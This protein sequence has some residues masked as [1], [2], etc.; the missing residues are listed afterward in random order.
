MADV[1]TKN[2]SIVPGVL[3]INLFGDG[4][5]WAVAVYLPVLGDL[6]GSTITGRLKTPGGDSEELL[7]FRTPENDEISRFSFGYSDTVAGF[8]TVS[9]EM[10]PSNPRSYIKGQVRIEKDNSL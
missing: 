4:Y 5:A 2:V 10:P 1:A 3:D 8:Y 7:I 9:I 6:T